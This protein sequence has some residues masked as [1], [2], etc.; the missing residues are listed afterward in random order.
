MLQTLTPP[1]GGRV[2]SGMQIRVSSQAYTEM[3]SSG[4]MTPADIEQIVEFFETTPQSW[5]EVSGALGRALVHSTS[6]RQLEAVLRRCSTA[7][8][9]QLA[10]FS[11]AMTPA[12]AQSVSV[13]FLADL[14]DSKNFAVKS[15]GGMLGTL[16][17]QQDTPRT[18]RGRS[19]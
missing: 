2:V 15:F 13:S 18:G 3:L 1:T 12:K 8:P 16:R 4:T 10:A 6:G 14:A 7:M 5:G 11:E 17:Q 9:E 19:L